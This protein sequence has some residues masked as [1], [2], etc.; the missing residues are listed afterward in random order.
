LPIV[1][2]SALNILIVPAFRVTNIRPSGVKAKATGFDKP[3]MWFVVV[4]WAF[5]LAAKATKEKAA[6]SKNF[7]ILCV[8]VM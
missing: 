1:E 7:F 5:R 3:E 8:F 6:I 2:P 4:Y